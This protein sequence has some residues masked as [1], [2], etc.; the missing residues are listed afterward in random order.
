[1]P[2]KSHFSLIERSVEHFFTD[3]LQ[4]K[5]SKIKEIKGELYGASIPLTSALEGEFDFYLL[6]SKEVFA[7]Y[8]AVFLQ[9][10]VLKEDDFTDLCKELANEIIGHA[11]ISINDSGMDFKLGIPEYLGRVDF[12]ELKLDYEVLLAANEA[13]FRIGYKKI[14]K[15]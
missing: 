4:C 2:K 5:L 11:K 8:K 6:F 3:I 9:D 10:L 7:R 13:P 15:K 1:M 14:G 12:E